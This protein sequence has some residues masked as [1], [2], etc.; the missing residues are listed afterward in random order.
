MYY[1]LLTHPTRGRCDEN[2]LFIPMERIS[3]RTHFFLCNN[4]DHI[5]IWAKFE[6][7]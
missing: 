5:P 3:W 6:L 7:F 4:D 2:F 1:E